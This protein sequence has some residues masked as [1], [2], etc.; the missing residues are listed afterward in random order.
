MNTENENIFSQ[1]KNGKES[2]LSREHYEE[3]NS[4]EFRLDLTQA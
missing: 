1:I 2:G 3:L 4:G